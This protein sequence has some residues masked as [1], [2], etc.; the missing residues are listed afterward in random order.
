[1]GKRVIIVKG[2]SLALQREKVERIEDVK[3]KCSMRPV[4]GSGKPRL[5]Q[6]LLARMESTR[7]LAEHNVEA[8]NATR[9]NDCEVIYEVRR[10]RARASMMAQGD[11][12]AELVEGGIIEERPVPF[13]HEE[14]IS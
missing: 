14:L 7:T 12:Q 13:L 3:R 9:I 4:K 2:T 1:M 5:L 10:K 11:L 6:K 8:M